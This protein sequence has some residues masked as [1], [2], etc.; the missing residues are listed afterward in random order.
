LGS[1]FRP[2]EEGPGYNLRRQIDAQM[3]RLLG[4]EYDWF[5]ELLETRRPIFEMIA[6]VQIRKL[7]MVKD[8]SSDKSAG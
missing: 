8:H 3:V 1:G 5:K 7:E 2:W 4:K 6:A